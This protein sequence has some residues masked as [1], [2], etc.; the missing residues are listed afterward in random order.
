M[1]YV[2]MGCDATIIDPVSAGGHV[3]A[4]YLSSAD[5]EG[6]LN[7]LDRS[8][9]R[10]CLVAR[11][12]QSLTLG[13]HTYSMNPANE[14][15]LTTQKRGWPLLELLWKQITQDELYRKWDSVMIQFYG[16]SFFVER[17]T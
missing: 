8:V 14:Y 4:G 7:S 10:T 1:M 12:A 15:T 6:Q 5:S 2:M 11:L 17:L 3:L 13:A 9:L 16:T